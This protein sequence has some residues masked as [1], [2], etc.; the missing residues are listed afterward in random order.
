RSDAG[1]WAGGGGGRE[2]ELLF[3]TSAGRLRAA[4]ETTITISPYRMTSHGPLAGIK[5]T[6]MLENLLALEEARSRGFTEA[7]MVNERGEIVGGTAANL[8]WVE[9]GDLFTPSLATG[10]VGGTTRGFVGEIARR[11]KIKGRDGSC[12]R[13]RLLD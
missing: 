7:L 12:Q 1:A 10:C 13:T 8:F 4:A 9:G 11:K 5:R 3:S 2:A 6:A